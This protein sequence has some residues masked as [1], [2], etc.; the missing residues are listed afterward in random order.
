MAGGG[1]M[2][3]AGVEE[4]DM[5]SLRVVI[6]DHGFPI[7]IQEVGCAWAIC[8]YKVYVRALCGEGMGVRSR[9]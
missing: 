2:W 9:G 4:N 8:A 5:R 1:R 6:M 7:L 3:L